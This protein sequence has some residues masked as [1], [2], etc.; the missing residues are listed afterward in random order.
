MTWAAGADLLV[1]ATQG[2]LTQIDPVSADETAVP[3]PE[4]DGAFPTAVAASPDGSLVAVGALDGTIRVFDSVTLELV[5][6]LAGHAAA[7]G[8]ST[9][10]LVAIRS[11][12]SAPIGRSS[13]GT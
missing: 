2:Q 1:W 7:V 3:L 12:P 5:A 10:S 11:R 4:Q 6:R 13:C 8:I 9:G